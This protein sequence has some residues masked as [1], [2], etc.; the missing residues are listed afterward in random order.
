MPKKKTSKTDI[1]MA[2]DRAAPLFGFVWSAKPPRKAGHYW[3]RTRGQ[4]ASIVELK[5]GGTQLHYGERIPCSKLP[6]W[7]WEWAGPIPEPN[8]STVPTRRAAQDDR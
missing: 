4:K 5:H 8:D 2:V 6:D 7:G 3:C 1:A